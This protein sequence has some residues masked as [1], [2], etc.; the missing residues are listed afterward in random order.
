MIGVC[1]LIYAVLLII[2]GI[3]RGNPFGSIFKAVVAGVGSAILMR[4]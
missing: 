3:S 2:S 1:L 4:I